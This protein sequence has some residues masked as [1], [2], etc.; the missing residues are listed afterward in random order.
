MRW[1]NQS[2]VSNTVAQFASFPC[3]QAWIQPKHHTVAFKGRRPYIQTNKHTYSIKSTQTLH[4]CLFERNRAALTFRTW[5]HY[6][7]S[8]NKHSIGEM[9]RHTNTGGVSVLYIA[10]FGRERQRGIA[11]KGTE[12]QKKTRVSCLVQPRRLNLSFYVDRS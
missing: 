2:L 10:H 8:V 12:K 7:S 9:L 5:H 1:Y 4:L 11:A 6:Q 3:Q